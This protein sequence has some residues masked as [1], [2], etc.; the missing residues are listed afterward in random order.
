MKKNEKLSKKFI[1]AHRPRDK[2]KY[3]RG[4]KKF[5][6]IGDEDGPLCPP[7]GMRKQH[8]YADKWDNG[9]IGTNFNLLKRYLRSRVGEDW[10]DVY[11]DICS[12]ADSRTFDGN[13]LREWLEFSVDVKTH[14]EDGKVVDKH[15]H[16]VMVSFYRDNFYVHPITNKLEVVKPQKK[17]KSWQE[18]IPKT[19]FELDHQ[20]YH[21]HEDIWYRVQM[22][23]ARKVISRWG[24]QVFSDSYPDQFISVGCDHN[25]YSV[26]RQL[27]AKY[28]YSPERKVWY[29]I[30]KESAN[31]KEIA[32][33]KKSIQQKNG[34]EY[35]ST[36]AI[37][38]K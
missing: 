14:M 3:P 1:E 28:G 37:G 21:E 38:V 27:R 23:E 35:I 17:K 25:Y 2:G 24:H 18:T 36:S 4:T 6:Q 31:S 11:S 26:E 30:H 16:D 33:L 32:K 20:L 8:L 13:H 7:S 10:D 34:C 29:C 19:V 9:Y 15:G 12:Q 5:K 22:Q